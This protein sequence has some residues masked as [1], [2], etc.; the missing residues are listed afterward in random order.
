MSVNEFIYP[1]IVKMRVYMTSLCSCQNAM[2]SS[3]CGLSQINVPISEIVI[4]IFLNSRKL[5]MYLRH[6]DVLV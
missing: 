5:K 6:Y 2:Y 1:C 3:L 4:S